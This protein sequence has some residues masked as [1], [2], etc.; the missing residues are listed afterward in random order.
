MLYLVS[1]MGVFSKVFLGFETSHE[2]QSNKNMRISTNC[3]L[4]YRWRR[5]PDLP[6]LNY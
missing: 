5:Y 4:D 3:S 6:P 2:A 1:Q